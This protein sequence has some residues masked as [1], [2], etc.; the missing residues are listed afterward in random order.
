MFQRI[1]ERLSGVFKKLKGHG[2]LKESNI[3]DALKEIKLSLL[4]ADVNYR[5][6]M[7]F[8]DSVR[9]RAMGK[10]VLN[11]LTPGQQFIKVVREE[12]AKVMGETWLGIELKGSPPFVVMLVG[13]QGSGKT[14]T[15]GKLARY[16]KNKGKNPLLVP[17]DPYRPAAT[18]QLEKL[19]QG[20]NVDVFSTEGNK[21]TRDICRKAL[22]YGK[23]KLYDIMII[24]TAGRLHI[25]D[26]LMGELAAVKRE[27]NPDEILFVADAMTGQDAVR[28]AEG[29]LKG[30]GIDGIIL[31]K[32]DG[33]A[34]GGAALSMKV[35][36]GRPIK[37]M[38]T[39]EK[40]DAL[41]PFHPDRIAGRIL[42]MGDV[43]TLIDKAVEEINKEDA[44]KLE[45]KL[46]KNDF[47][48]ED[49]RT[50]IRQIKKMG[51]LDSILGMMP[52]FNEI[53]K[54]GFKV[55]DGALT[56]VEAI[57]NSMTLEER[58]NPSILNG[59][60][61]KRIAKGSG[62]AV[63][64]VNKLIKQ[65]KQTSKLLASMKKKGFKRGIN[66]FNMQGLFG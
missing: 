10:D 28:I 17:A 44:A 18:L 25:D 6:V 37:F 14:T 16:F 41:E 43:L 5:V 56:R 51:P 59:S 48:F 57:I 61:R 21:D 20:L 13:L 7:D 3:K 60:R 33:D 49:F 26:E 32:L 36:T 9:T 38:G 29:F 1:S 65:H 47:T 24:D 50:H 4:E 64:D 42:G 8:L 12:L 52:G 11:S 35:V 23:G 2:V 53:K 58:R 54:K 27:I 39:G 63:Q 31:T 19:G 46:R 30:V 55:D 22:R 66:P 34:R 45:K 40:L 15:A 62:T